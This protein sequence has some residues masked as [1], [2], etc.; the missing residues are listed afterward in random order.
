M[1]ETQRNV[2]QLIVV[3]NMARA[4]A[5]GTV[6]NQVTDL[7][8]GEVVWVTPGGQ[9]VD[10]SSPN[11]ASY[12]RLRL[13]WRNGSDLITSD[14]IDVSTV[15][16]YTITSYAAGT[17]QVDYVGYNGSSLALQ[18]I[19]ENLYYMRFF[20]W[21]L[22][23]TDFSAQT[24]K[25]AVY[26][27]GTTATQYDTA[28]GLVSSLA[29]NFKTNR[30]NQDGYVRAD[31]VCNAAAA[32]GYDF[33]GNFTVVKGS[34]QAVV[35]SS[36]TYNTGTSLAAG[37]YVRVG[38]TSTTAVALTS[39]VYKVLAI[40][41]TTTQTLTFDHA[42]TEASGTYA[43]AGNYTQVILAATAQAANWGIKLTGV[44]NKWAVGKLPYRKVRWDVA[45][46]D[47]G[48]AIV[49]SSASPAEGTGDYRQVQELE[50]FLQGNEGV[51]FR[52]EDWGP[53]RDPR[54]VASSAETYDILQI[55]YG[56]VL[57]TDL[58]KKNTSPK[59]I[60]LA[61]A[62]TSNDA[63]QVYGAAD[64]TSI[65]KAADYWIVTSWTIAG[66]TAQVSNLT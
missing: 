2:D 26:K 30:V 56:H 48:T 55:R 8:D 27:S 15:T 50:Y 32:A 29:S 10:N 25:N 41:G 37:D 47:F 17:E 54:I 34:T 3:K 38:A 59:Q 36:G 7:N 63:N 18:A 65:V 57:D 40:S 64:Y 46:E 9:V 31:M 44:A 24:I 19:D 14:D 11:A 51:P 53:S 43:T 61:L 21:G 23:S 5:A 1:L 60:T 16:G 22:S 6:I 20:M 12:T 49:T 35:T 28:I 45:L 66:M 13:L 42:V 58:G 62:V 52:H 39:S 33:D 4:A